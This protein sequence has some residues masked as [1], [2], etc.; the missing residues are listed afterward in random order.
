MDLSLSTDRLRLGFEKID[1]D[2]DRL[3]NAFAD[4]LRDLGHPEIAD[5]LP[6]VGSRFADPDHRVDPVDLCQATTIA[7]HL[8]NIVEENAANQMRRHGE[9]TSGLLS[10]SGLWG[11]YFKRLSDAGVDPAAL[12]DTLRRATV[13]PVL[14]AHPTESKRITVL[15]QHRE[16]YVLLVDL[17]NTMYTPTEQD[18]IEGRIRAVLERLW[19]TGE[20]LLEKPTVASERNAMLHYLRNVFPHAVRDVDVHLR[21]AWNAAG[22]DPAL[23]DDPEELPTLRFGTWVGGD[24]DGHPL[25]TSAVTRETFAQL[26][27]NAIRLQRA[28]LDRLRAELSLSSLLVAPP[29]AFANALHDHLTRLGPVGEEIAGRNPAEPWRQFVSAILESLPPEDA[30]DPSPIPFPHY[31]NAAEL[32][33]D[34]RILRDSLL[35]VGADR[36]ARACVDP[37]IRAARTF[38]FHLARLDIRQNSGFHDRA[39]DQILAA[40]GFADPEFSAWDEPR[41]IEFLNQTLSSTIPLLPLNAY[42]DN[43]AGRAVGAFREVARQVELNGDEGVGII[44]LSMTRTVSDLLAVYFLAR[45]AGLLLQ[46]DYGIVC[47]VPISPLLE[48]IDDLRNGSAILGRFIEHPITAASIQ[49]RNRRNAEQIAAPPEAPRVDVMVGYSDSNKDGGIIASQWTLH[50]SQQA[51]AATTRQQGV[52]TRFFHGRGGTISRGAG[53]THRFLEALP[54]SSIGDGLRLTEQGETIAQKY[55]NLLTASHNLDLLLSGT[56]YRAFSDKNPDSVAPER[57]HLMDRVAEHSR[58]TYRS[59]LETSDFM[60]FYRQATPIDLLESSR[61]GSRPSRRT[62]AASLDDLRAIPWVFSWSQSRFFLPGWY[63]VGTALKAILNDDPAGAEILR[64]AIRD[65]PFLRYV[66]TNVEMSSLSTDPIIFSAYADLV[67]DPAIRTRFLDPI[68]KEL[69][70][71]REV[72]NTIFGSDAAKRRPRLFKTLAPRADA[73]RPLHALQIQLLREWRSARQSGNDARAEEIHP[74]LLLSVNAIS[75]GLRTTG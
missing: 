11:W 63:G 68:L 38:G 6:W 41:R 72:L 28:N 4:V 64:T 43:E 36:L 45:E 1:R 33:G 31:R 19:R 16:L 51:I 62:G 24:R 50:Q 47:R 74:N 65:W 7:F 46:T 20:T 8:L 12:R 54:P 30:S 52:T 18:A 34:L 58:Q 23:I 9:R 21:A 25:V 13:E 32:I 66:L 2:R 42:A 44:I 56:M 40:A 17:E 60:A 37:V 59:L 71:T 55:G 39:I 48:T 10:E 70:R 14:T 69:E 35:A 22:F 3:L 61:I 15:E 67:E 57:V 27:I 75:S 49:W 53:P 5:A 26:R 29:P 73:I